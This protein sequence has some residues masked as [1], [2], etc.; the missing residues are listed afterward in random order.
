MSRQSAARI[1][2]VED[3]EMVRQGIAALLQSEK[4]L[5]IVGGTGDGFEAVR[6]AEE[7]KP[8]VV[9]M[10]LT[11]RGRI[12]GI[13]AT[14][15]I[16]DRCPDVKV[17]I[18]SMH[19]DAPTVDRALKAGARGYVIKGRGISSL[20]DAIRAVRRGDMYLSP[21]TSEYVVQGYAA[22]SAEPRARLS[23]RECEVLMLIAEG[24]TGRQIAERLGLRPKTVDNHRTRIMEK[25]DIHTTAG[26]VRY[27][28]RE[29]L[30]RAPGARASDD[31]PSS[32]PS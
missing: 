23:E 22:A 9:V 31:A 13:E 14:A 20:C 4:D 1:L 2:I 18:L 10:D 25:L 21:D 7:L 30:A 28:L 12:S 8:D 29:G 19:D 15:L 32:K 6:M 5:E 26:L 11:L 27:A 3:H 17:V 24:H 16:R